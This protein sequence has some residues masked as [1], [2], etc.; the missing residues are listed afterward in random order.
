MAHLTVGDIMTTRVETIGM[1]QSL[2][3]VRARFDECLYHHMIIKNE[4]GVCVG[5]ISDRDLL[6]HL[7][8]FVG[9]MAERSTDVG[10]LSK[11][12]HQI[13]TRQLIA[14]RPRTMFRDAARIMLDHKISC[15]PVLDADHKCV[16]IVTLRDVVRWTADMLDELNSR[17]A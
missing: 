3:D 6:K 15:L 5:V 16:G 8:P 11:R 13:M 10:T 7:S 9:K 2:R 14:V 1:D 17:A 4:H 12:V